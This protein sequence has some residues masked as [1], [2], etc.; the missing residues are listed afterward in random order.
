MKEQPILR[1]TIWQPYTGCLVAFVVLNVAAP[2][3]RAIERL[4]C[5]N[6]RRQIDDHRALIP[7]VEVLSGFERI[8]RTAVIVLSSYESLDC[9]FQF[10]DSLGLGG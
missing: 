1:N 9:G 8:E 2:L 3:Q 4:G 10:S 5:D 6:A 7:L